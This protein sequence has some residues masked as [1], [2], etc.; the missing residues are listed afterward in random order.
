MSEQGTR[1]QLH[2][3]GVFLTIAVA[4]FV[5]LFGSAAS[6][7]ALSIW[8]YQT[9]GY[10]QYFA[11]VLVVSFVP[12]IILSPFAGVL[13]DRKEPRVL[14]LAGSILGGIAITG[15]LA[16]LLTGSLTVALIL[17]VTALLS[18]ASAL[19]APALDA[20]IPFIVPRERVAQANGIFSICTSASDISGPILAGIFLGL[21]NLA[22]IVAFDLFTYLVAILVTLAIWR[23]LA[24]KDRV[25][26]A[27]WSTE[28]PAT[29]RSTWKQDLKAGGRYLVSR[30]PLF[31]LVM[32]FTLLNF[33]LGANEVIGQPF[34]LS[35]GTAA[36]LGLLNAIF[37]SGMVLGSLV[38]SVNKQ[39]G[40]KAKTI[41]LGNLGIGG[42]ITL[43]SFAHN[44]WFVGIAWLAIGLLIPVV[45]TSA[46]TI[47]QLHTDPAYLGRVLSLERMLS[48]ISLP[49]AE[50]IAGFFADL[51][52]RSGIFQKDLT[53]LTSYFGSGRHEVYSLFILSMGV[54]IIIT[55]TLF[56]RS[57]TLLQLD[58]GGK[59][60][61]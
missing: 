30:K 54:F 55:T 34:A 12:G 35:L 14:I 41:L 15:I 36:Q 22:F 38:M 45:N 25:L 56:A 9:T 31:Q 1:A 24:T 13:I 6:R 61:V 52:I 2:G 33:A 53:P 28:Q 46:I 59:N 8:V 29:G 18:C 17:V 21:G 26:S 5:T 3:L 48:W 20:I 44:I 4:Q 32:L 50:V 47:L 58:K 49:V 16:A 37:G 43:S 11:L 60:E 27:P 23:Q 40:K 42:A 51:L 19:Q 57:H 39:E 10:V 7:F